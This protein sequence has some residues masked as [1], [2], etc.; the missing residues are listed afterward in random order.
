MGE[1]EKRHE[2]S[3]MCGAV[4]FRVTGELGEM[5]NCHC[6]HCRKSHAAAFAAYIMVAQRDFRFVRGAAH[7][8]THAAPTGTKRSFCRRCGSIVTCWND[9][10]RVYTWI[11]AST[12][13]TPITITPAYHT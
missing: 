8:T 10:D 12:L 1:A 6:T 13:D 2:G 11:T 5:M 4:K 7:L 3:C 9:D